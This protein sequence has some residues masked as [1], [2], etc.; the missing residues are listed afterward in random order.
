MTRLAELT[1]EAFR[2]G[3]T[4]PAPATLARYGLTS[5]EWLELFA[6]QGWKCPICLKPA[7]EIKT[8]T[9]HEHAAGWDKMK[10]EEKKRYTRGILC[11]YCNYRRV[12]SKIS[13]TIAQRIATYISEYE[14]RRDAA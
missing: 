14:K 13:A 10:P 1:M 5:L 2:H 8:N 11:S 6:A 9:D 4:P 3:A 7:A 12:H